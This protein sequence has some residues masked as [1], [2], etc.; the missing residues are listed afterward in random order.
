MIPRKKQD[1]KYNTKLQF[2]TLSKKKSWL[3]NYNISNQ[4][5]QEKGTKRSQKWKQ[6]GKCSRELQF[7]RSFGKKIW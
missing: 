2:Y 5:S 4:I 1:W 7:L 3:K 6:D